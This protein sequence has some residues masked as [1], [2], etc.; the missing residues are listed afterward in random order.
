MPTLTRHA[1]VAFSLSCLFF[2][3]YKVKRK[4]KRKRRGEERLTS[5]IIDCNGT[6]GWRIVR[7]ANKCNY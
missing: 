1:S 7:K 2:L 6:G 3:E 4:R 5:G